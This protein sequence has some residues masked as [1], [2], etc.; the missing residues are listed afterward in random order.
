MSQATRCNKAQAQLHAER[1]RCL[2][3]RLLRDHD[4]PRLI[5]LVAV[6]LGLGALALYAYLNQL[7]PFN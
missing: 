5:E 6:L 7:A 1:Q 2:G 4:R 3:E